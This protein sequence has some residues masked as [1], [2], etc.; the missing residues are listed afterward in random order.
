MGSRKKNFYYLILGGVPL[1]LLLVLWEAAG[2]I[3]LFSRLALP[4]PSNVF[5]ALGHEIVS[6][7][8]IHNWGR[9]LGVWVVSLL[10]ASCLAFASVSSLERT[11]VSA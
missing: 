7:I 2:R 5:I 6:P 9:T 3:G 11:A 8:F 1:V 4:L 10:V